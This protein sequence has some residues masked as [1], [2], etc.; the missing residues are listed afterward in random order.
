VLKPTHVSFECLRDKRANLCFA[1]LA[2]PDVSGMCQATIKFLLFSGWF[3]GSSDVSRK[4]RRSRVPAM[5]GSSNV[6][7]LTNLDDSLSW[8][9]RKCA[10]FLPDVSGMND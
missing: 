5:V 2:I 10:V 4:F 1:G 6:S 9:Y 7:C 3:V 8:S